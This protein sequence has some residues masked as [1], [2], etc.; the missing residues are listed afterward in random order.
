[1]ER[2]ARAVKLT[3]LCTMIGL[4]GCGQSAPP[5][6]RA[7]FADAA[8]RCALDLTTYTY[9]D[10]LVLDEPLI[11]FTKEPEP[12]KAHACFNAALEKVDREMTKRGVDHISYVWEWR[13]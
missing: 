1:M 13:A 2:K 12:A 11:D 4:V 9:R 7:T 8:R 5:M 3:A 6:S 10:G